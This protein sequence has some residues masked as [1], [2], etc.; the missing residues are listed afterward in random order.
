VTK[1]FRRNKICLMLSQCYD[2]NKMELPLLYNYKLLWLQLTI[3]LCSLA[4]KSCVT[5]PCLPHSH[6]L[7]FMLD[8]HNNRVAYHV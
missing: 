1:K 6:A 8:M 4:A 2:G 7:V 5:S 3:F